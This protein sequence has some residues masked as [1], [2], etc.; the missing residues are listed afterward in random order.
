[1]SQAQQDVPPVAGFSSLPLSPALIQVAQELGFERLTPIQAQAIPLLLQ[2][3]DVVAQSVTGSGKTVAFTL[4]ILDKLNTADRRIQALV[5][6]PTREL[7]AQVTREMRKLARRHPGVQVL[8]L[9]GG[10]PVNFQAQALARGVHIVV[11]TPG[12]ILDHLGRSALNLTAVT[13]VVLDEADR[14]LDMGFQK[15]VERVLGS[16]PKERQTLFF[17]ATYPNSIGAMSRAHQRNPVRITIQESQQAAP[18][19]QQ[20]LHTVEK[21][22]K[23]AAVLAL[24]HT[25]QPQSALIFCNHKATV[26]ELAE[27]LG[28]DGVSVDLLHGDLEQNDRD[29]VLAKFRNHSTRVL[30]ATDVAARGLD[31]ENLDLVINHD[32]PSKPEI[33][34]HRIGRTG[35]A[36]KRGLAVTLATAK[37]ATKVQSIEEYTGVRME[38]V[39]LAY[40]SRHAEED[41]GDDAAPPPPAHRD[42]SMDTLYVSGGRKDKMRPGDILGALTGDGGLAATDVG[43]IE[44]HDRFSYVAVARSASKQAVDT[45][46]K[47]RIKGRRFK[48]GFA[49]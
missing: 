29:R 28:Q 5:L 45:L 33:H 17:S 15:D 12:R 48:V 38:R 20:V 36:G 16:L 26:D 32:I 37:E 6:C 3:K 14:M 35:R 13:T 11:G 1:M 9:A 44:I 39:E 10:E 4:P 47:G 21:E 24:L 25:H 34:V 2:G 41:A 30:I 8:P 18:D 7:C 19:I 27:A 43:K 22:D 46:S 40:P 42:A 23:E 49:T 31:V